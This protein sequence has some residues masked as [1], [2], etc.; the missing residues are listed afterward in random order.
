MYYL[1]RLIYLILNYKYFMCK[2]IN[3]IMKIDF[4]TLILFED[5]MHTSVI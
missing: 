2:I 3:L 4:K 1:K 5:T